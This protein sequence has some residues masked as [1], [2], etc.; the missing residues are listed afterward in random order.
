MGDDPLLGQRFARES[1]AV[2][3]RSYR[4]L[5]DLS[6]GTK[7]VGDFLHGIFSSPVKSLEPGKGQPSS[8]LSAKGKL[9]AAFGLH[10]L[11]GGRYRMAFLEPLDDT[12]L[13][14]LGK[15]CFLSDV[16]IE[17]LGPVLGTLSV[18]GPEAARVLR[19]AGIGAE[20]PASSLASM[21]AVL[22]GVAVTIIRGGETP[23]GGFDIW[24][25][26]PSLDRVREA[27]V[28]AAR[29]AGGGPADCD[30]A[31]ALRIEAGIAHR[32]KD[33]GADDAFPAEV[34]WEH[35]LTY[36]KCYVG[37][38]VVA[39]MKTYG[40]ANRRLKGL[41]FAPGENPP[42]PGTRILWGGEDVG[43]IGSSAFSERIGRA[44]GLGM[45]HRKAWGA[46]HVLVGEDSSREA[47]VRDLPL[48]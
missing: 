12:V 37:Q 24:L 33:Y 25:E 27:L 38:E 34:G 11:E 1:A 40:H 15:Y 18:E 48:A 10:A 4:G 36:D 43:R 16:T 32:G 31:E 19:L 30:A 46:G 2:F 26:R 7:P 29:L 6:G 13:K 17:D 5:V 21:G 47:E 39:R 23:R 14:P 41:V 8:F 20:L 44:I 42:I 9:I 35:A 3:D 28:A 22:A 45:V